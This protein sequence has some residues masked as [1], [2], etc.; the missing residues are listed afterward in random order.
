MLVMKINESRKRGLGSPLIRKVN[1]IK[2]NKDLLTR[3]EVNIQ[4]SKSRDNLRSEQVSP[5]KRVKKTFSINPND[6]K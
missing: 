1:Y 3:T 5:L 4:A 6:N 2:L